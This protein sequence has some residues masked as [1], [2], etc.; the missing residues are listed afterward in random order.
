MTCRQSRP[1]D[2]FFHRFYGVNRFNVYIQTFNGEYRLILMSASVK[3]T[4]NLYR[5]LA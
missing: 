5:R 4:Y 1:V 3:K 2:I